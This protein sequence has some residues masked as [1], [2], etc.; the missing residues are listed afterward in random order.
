MLYCVILLNSRLHAVVLALL[1]YTLPY[2]IA[3]SSLVLGRVDAGCPQPHGGWLIG[4]AHLKPR[5]VLFSCNLWH[6][7][8]VV[9][10]PDEACFTFHNSPL[11]DVAPS[12]VQLD[13]GCCSAHSHG[14][15]PFS[16]PVS[17][18]NVS[19]CQ[20]E[21]ER[22]QSNTDF[23]FSF[24]SSLA[25][26]VPGRSQLSQKSVGTLFNLI[27]ESITWKFW[28]EMEECTYSTGSSHSELQH[29]AA[30]SFSLDMICGQGSGAAALQP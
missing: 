9:L 15:V 27:N 3:Q 18:K 6:P 14:I 12:S 1:H 23:S 2:K 20:V 4:S 10:V 16:M 28:R 8:A 19:A 17:P 7:T 11:P 21:K 5:S 30:S 29:R 13:E 24:T 26:K 25:S 22:T